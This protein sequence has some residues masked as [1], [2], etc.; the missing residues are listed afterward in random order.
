ML[1]LLLGRRKDA[2]TL[3]PDQVSLGRLNNVREAL[4][5]SRTARTILGANGVS[6]EYPVLR[7]MKTSSRS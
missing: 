1:A 2:G 7:H 6:L 3:R 5:I 4:D